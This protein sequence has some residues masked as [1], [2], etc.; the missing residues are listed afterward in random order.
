VVCSWDCGDG[1]ELKTDEEYLIEGGGQDPT[2]E[3]VEQP[4]LRISF[5]GPEP[6]LQDVDDTSAT[7]AL[8]SVAEDDAESK[9]QEDSAA[10]PGPQV[11]DIPSTPSVKA[12]P[13]K[14]L[15]DSFHLTGTFAKWVTD[16]APSRLEQVPSGREG[17]ARLK[18]CI[19]LTSQSF[20]FQVVSAEQ[21]WTWRL[22]PRDAVN[23]RFTHVSKEGKL[24]AG[25]P[26]EVIVGLGGSKAGHGLNFHVIEAAGVVVSI[27]I[28]VPVQDSRKEPSVL[29]PRYDTVDGARVWYTLEDTGVQ[30]TGGDNVDLNKYS[31]MGLG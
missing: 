13:M 28:E 1:S 21:K 5:P 27:W 19:K 2:I 31:W 26:D 16:F 3:E 24:N 30:Y 6:A 23:I 7:V 25:N 18:I 12:P 17:V 4:P 20:S 15:K 10:V 11:L 14:R 9:P 22:Y 8:A 29:E